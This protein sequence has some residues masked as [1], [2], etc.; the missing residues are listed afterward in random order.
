M[1][2]EHVSEDGGA[3]GRERMWECGDG[4]LAIEGAA[5]PLEWGD[6]DDGRIT[7]H[8]LDNQITVG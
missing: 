8:G 5:V 6:R 7:R 2:K 1:A 4:G 3:V